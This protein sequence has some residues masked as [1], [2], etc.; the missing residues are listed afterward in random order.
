[1]VH[2]GRNGDVFMKVQSFMLDTPSS[3]SSSTCSLSLAG[4]HGVTAPREEEEKEEEE[5]AG[6]GGG[7][8]GGVEEEEEGLSNIKL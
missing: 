4:Q 5:E 1:M 3:S 6:G 7:G 8:E 2:I